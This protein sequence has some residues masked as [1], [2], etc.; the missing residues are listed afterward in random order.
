M[1]SNKRGN[2]DRGQASKK[3]RKDADSQEHPT[4]FEMELAMLDEE[5]FVSVSQ[6]SI[7][8]TLIPIIIIF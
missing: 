3:P 2:S 8:Q 7:G 1:I 4:D 6:E 5:D